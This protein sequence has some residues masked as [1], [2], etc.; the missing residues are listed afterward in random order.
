MK[1]VKSIFRFVRNK[2]V[3]SITVVAVWVIF[4]DKNN[5]FSQM[6][7]TRQ[8]QKLTQE[9]LYYQERIEENKISLHDLQTSPSSLEKFA[10]ETYMMKKDNEDIFVIVPDTVK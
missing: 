10:R 8:L 2:Y 1:A 9:K 4:L 7:L 6:E 5:V 3:L